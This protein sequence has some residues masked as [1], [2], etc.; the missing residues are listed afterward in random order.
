MYSGRQIYKSA[1]DCIVLHAN[2]RCRDPDLASLL[3]IIRQPNSEDREIPN[4]LWSEFQTTW[5]G[6]TEHLSPDN[7][8]AR[9]R[10]PLFLNGA[11]RAIEWQVA[12]RQQI[13]RAGRDA[14]QAGQLLRYVA[15]CDRTTT[16]LTKEEFHHLLQMPNM[17]KTGRMMGISPFHVEARVILTQRI[18]RAYGL[19]LDAPGAV[20]GVDYQASENPE[21]ITNPTSNVCR[22]RVVALQFMP[23]AIHVAFDDHIPRITGNFPGHGHPPGVF[24]HFG[25]GHPPGV[26]AKKPMTSSTQSID[27]L[28]IENAKR[29]QIQ[30]SRTQIPLTP[31]NMRTS[32]GRQGISTEYVIIDCAQPRWLKGNESGETTCWLNLYVMLSRARSMEQMLLINAPSRTTHQTGPPPSV[33]QELQRLRRS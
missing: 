10:N 24:A 3:N 28:S 17:T 5:A 21:W 8:D 15:A 14:A 20:A 25:H 19:V 22:S 26:F 1:T 9:S 11:F 16:N 2:K 31:H 12:A 13:A 33:L 23:L 7:Q 4:A 6:A 32:Y 29:R 27:L 30:A 18:S